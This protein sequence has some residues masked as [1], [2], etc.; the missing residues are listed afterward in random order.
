[1]RTAPLVAATAAG[2]TVAVGVGFGVAAARPSDTAALVLMAVAVLTTAGVGALIA[3]R[4]PGHL[5]ALVLSLASFVYSTAFLAEAYARFVILEDHPQFPAGEWAVLWTNAS[6]STMFA[7]VIAIA[8]VFP[9]GH[10][11]SPRWRPIA[12]AAVVCVTG[13]V[14]MGLFSS[15]P[16]DRPFREVTNPLPAV[17]GFLEPL[18]LVFLLGLAALVIAAGVAVR[19]RFVRAVQLERQQLLWLAG[20]AWLIPATLAVCLLDVVLPGDLDWLVIGMLLLTITAVPASIAVALLRYR[21]YDL[22]LLVNRTLVYGALT[23]LVFAAYYSAVVGIGR[24]VGGGESLV[25]TLAATAVVVVMVNPLRVWLQHRVDRLMYGDRADPYAGLSRLAD[26]LEVSVTPQMA[27]RIIVETVRES[28]KASFV[29][30]DLSRADGVLHRAAADGGPEPSRAVEVP[31]HFQGESVGVLVVGPRPGE[32]LAAA[33]RRLLGELARHAGAVVHAARVTLELQASRER[34]VAAQEEVRRR[35]RRDLHDELGPTLAG[36]VFQVDLARDALPPEATAVDAQLKQL[37]TQLQDAVG[38]IRDMAYALRPPALDDG[39]V[40][41][42]W[43]QVSAI[44]ARGSGPFITLSAPR[45][46]PQLTPAVETAAYRIV[47]EAVGN[48]DRHSG[49]KHC[50][51]RLRLKGGLQLEVSDDGGAGAGTPFRPGVGIASMRE[52]ASE[53][54]ATLTIEQTLTGTRVHTVLP[55]GDG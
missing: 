55:V 20:S 2:L 37:R 32:E 29:A 42:L 23:A 47:I 28:L 26:R 36:A 51:I 21:L 17:P 24:I 12:W 44:N 8:F 41:A 3:V 5:V 25:V 45:S 43:Q 1:M 48:A 53:L 27:L 18:Q 11:P 52:R 46:L 6:W 19:R 39:L 10:L 22:D 31:L 49:A 38:S 40:P 54:G 16:F 35:L 14:V 9:D 30:I 50:D 7:G 15:E 34:L 33:D 13:M 4:V